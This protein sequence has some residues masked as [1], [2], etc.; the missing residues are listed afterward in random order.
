[1]IIGI[2]NAL[3]TMFYSQIEN[4]RTGSWYL[5]TEVSLLTDAFENFKWFIQ[6][7]FTNNN[8][9]K[10]CLKYDKNCLTNCVFQAE[11][12]SFIAFFATYKLYQWY[13][14]IISWDIECF[15]RAEYHNISLLLKAFN[16]TGVW[17]NINGIQEYLSFVQWC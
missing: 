15:L 16:P 11:K 13:C 8:N 9:K 1:M 12:E 3:W 2:H 7:C 4:N 5:K 10:M 6:N 14:F 17:L